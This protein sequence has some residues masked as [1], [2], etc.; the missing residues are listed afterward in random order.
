MTLQSKRA[1][2]NLV[3]KLS[4]GFLH[5]DQITLALSCRWC[6]SYSFAGSFHSPLSSS[7]FHSSQ[8]VG[9]LREDQFSS[10]VNCVLLA[11][12][13]SQP[14]WL[15]CMER[16]SVFSPCMLVPPLVEPS[17]ARGH[18]HSWGMLPLIWE[19]WHSFKADNCAHLLHHSGVMTHGKHIKNQTFPN[20]DHYSCN[21]LFPYYY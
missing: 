15:K 9:S 4:C 17:W 19:H 1:Y 16:Q 12:P 21:P 7:L 6:W 10:L 18:I 14:L 5:V 2:Q 8:L 13:Q 3:D 20:S 11:L